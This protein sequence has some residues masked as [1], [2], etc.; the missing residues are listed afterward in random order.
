MNGR[1]SG[2]REATVDVVVVGSGF[3]GSVAALRLA[4]KG[5]RVAVLEAGRRFADADFAVSPWSVHRV[6]WAPRFGLR[7]IVRVRLGRHVVALTGVGVGGGSLAYAGVHYRPGPEVFRGE[8]WDRSVDWSAEL[9]P[10]F[11]RA[12]RMLGTTVTPRLAH[13]DHLLRRSAE[14]L[15]AQATFHPVRVGVHFGEPGRTVADPYFGGLGPDRA[16]CLDCGRCTFGCPVGAKNTLM[17]NYLHLAERAGARI[18]PLTTV[19]GLRPV[20][21]GGWEIEATHPGIGRRRSWRAG[22]VV[23]AAGAWGTTEL[24]HRCRA[25]GTLPALSP[26]LGTRM[27]TNGELIL[28]ATAR[29][30]DVGEGTAITSA[31]HADEATMVQLCRV[32][33]GMH[34]LTGGRGQRTAFL[35]TM[36]REDPGLL[37][38]YR[39]GRLRLSRGSASPEPRS[40]A[41]TA[42]QVVAEQAGGRPSRW[43]KAL[44]RKPVT[45]HLLGGC[46]M[47]TDPATSVVD[48]AHRVHGH[49]G[50]HIADASVL[51]HNLGVNPSLTITALAERAFAAWAPR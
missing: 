38:R 30:L 10:H 25:A 32:G 35:N 51:P 16:G 47:G 20:R 2:A 19:T 4:E 29:A 40:A 5:Y 23:L 9:D 36:T 26:A 17:K 3:G 45:A 46:P 34:P 14:V 28:T 12:E 8:G 11:T 31:F 50:L 1:D 41:M 43:W 6:V 13:G 48:L 22:H 42:A 49:P 37:G 33:R 44:L 39:G 24:L 27:G 7:G 15:G 21:D 18:H